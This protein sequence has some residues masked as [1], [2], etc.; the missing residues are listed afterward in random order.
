V[1]D[2]PDGEVGMKRDRRRASAAAGN[3]S[4]IRPKVAHQVVWS[5]DATVDNPLI[6]TAA[7]LRIEQVGHVVHHWRVEDVRGLRDSL[8]E[9]LDRAES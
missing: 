2:L 3:I 8:T 9:V 6:I 4:Q 1:V 5:V 7:G